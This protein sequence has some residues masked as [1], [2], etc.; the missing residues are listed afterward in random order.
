[1]C[2]ALGSIFHCCALLKK[3]NTL[4]DFYTPEMS[5]DERVLTNI[6]RIR[7]LSSYLKTKYIAVADGN[8]AL[9]VL[10]GVSERFRVLTVTVHTSSS[11]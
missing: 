2:K 7:Q 9:R 1:M 11:D 4:G 5:D 3:V 6:S 8:A 10:C